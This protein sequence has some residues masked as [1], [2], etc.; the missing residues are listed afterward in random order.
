V[1]DG[2]GGFH[3]DAQHIDDDDDDSDIEDVSTWAWCVVCFFGGF[4]SQGRKEAGA[5]DGICDCRWRWRWQIQIQIQ[6]E[7]EDSREA[8]A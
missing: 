7:D 6:I 3:A 2:G 8:W 1:A 4:I 5:H